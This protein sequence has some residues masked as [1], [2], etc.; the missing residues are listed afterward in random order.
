MLLLYNHDYLKS[1][2]VIVCSRY[3][4]AVNN[5]LRGT[6]TYTP[7]RALIILAIL[8]TAQFNISVKVQ[9]APINAFDKD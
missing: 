7:V 6:V 2:T 9:I 5:F 3:R 4:V 8:W 1:I